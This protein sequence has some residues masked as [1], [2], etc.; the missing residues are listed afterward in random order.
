MTTVALGGWNARGTVAVAANSRLLAAL[1]AGN[2]TG[3]SGVG[4]AGIPDLAPVVERALTAAGL[5]QAD[6]RR[7]VLVVDTAAVVGL[8]QAHERCDQAARSHG[9][10]FAPSTVVDADAATVAFAHRWAPGD[11]SPV[12]YAGHNDAWLHAGADRIHI[13]GYGDLVAA[14]SRL[15]S[16]LGFERGDPWTALQALAGAT[17]P[18]PRW[19]ALLRGVVQAEGRAV[20]VDLA[21]LDEALSDAAATVSVP[22]AQRDS[23]HRGAAELRASL[24]AAWL[25]RVGQTLEDVGGTTFIWAGRVG[26]LPSVSC[27]SGAELLPAIDARAA[28]VGA[29]LDDSAPGVAVSLQQVGEHFDETDVK[30]ALEAARLDYLYEPRPERLMQRVSSLL[31]SGRLVGWFEGRDDLGDVPSGGRV[32]VADAAERYGRDNINVYLRRRPVDESLVVMTTSEAARD[33]FGA[34]APAPGQRARLAVPVARREW[35]EGA[36]S[37]S[38]TVDVV[39]A[40]PTHVPG[41]DALLRHHQ[42][43]TGHPALIVAPLAAADGPTASRPSDALAVTYA[44]PVDALVLGRFVVFKDYWLLRSGLTLA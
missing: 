24:A 26:S 39:T 5:K 38:G 16:A 19:S 14:T 1:D 2:V 37:A 17:A 40:D 13:Q 44:T 42:A 30:N 43:E 25:Q 11:P 41:L 7:I 36:I 21:R 20:G 33:L 27:R 34:R 18:A 4:L 35:F 32:I 8:A 12:L 3:L 28:V 29:A 10:L 9:L 23:P 31:S 6:V 15:S 22:L